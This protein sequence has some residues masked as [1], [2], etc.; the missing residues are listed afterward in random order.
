[1]STKV[2]SF[3]YRLASYV[4]IGGVSLMM[5]MAIGES[6]SNN[7]VAVSGVIIENPFVEVA[8]KVKPAVVQ[9][10]TT[11][12]VKY[13]YWDPFDDS[14]GGQFEDLFPEFF[15][16]RQE[17][18]RKPREYKRKQEGLGSGFIIDKEGYILTNYHVIKEVD[19]IQVKLLGEDKKY[20]AEVV[21]E[22]DSATD[23]AVL[24]IEP[25]GRLTVAKF[26]DSDKLKVGQWV[27]AIGNPF[28][29]EESVTQGVISAKGRSGFVGMPRYQDFIQTD[30]SINFG[31]SG[32]P[33]VNVKG[34]VVGISTFIISPY[35]SQG[36]GFAIPINM[37]KKV[38]GKI[39]EH[40]R[41]VR[42]YLGIIPDDVDPAMAKKWKLPG[43]VG[44]VVTDVEDGTPASLA[45][46]KV[47]DVI[48][49]F[50]GKEVTGEDEF[51]KMVA[52]TPVSKKVEIKVIRD[53]KEKVLKVEIG[54]LPSE[55]RVGMGVEEELGL[56]LEVSEITPSMAERYDLEETRGVI[57]VDVE[58]GSPADGKIERGDIIKEINDNKIKSMEDYLSALD[59][60]KPGEDIIF[61]I[62]RGKYTTF[63]VV[64]IE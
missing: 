7:A 48:I 40:G 55:T 57:V 35:V 56:G 42:G 23:V 45:G 12:V 37:A 44:V 5:G 8:E 17:K 63:V 22:P 58:P 6:P 19:E 30:A 3:F 52:D 18:R 21:G 31:N 24:K 10:T 43:E 36:V 29:L 50:D 1:M 27:I 53:G 51:R 49:E 33:L 38:Y 4:V 62:R 46:V 16:R 14:F 13:R 34:E 15:G 9:I 2:V 47:K 59:E 61:F 20:T 25:R 32:G 60:V 26:G 28:G 54:E 39:I 41:V 11:K 64:R